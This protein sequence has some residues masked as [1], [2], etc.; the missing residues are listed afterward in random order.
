MMWI[1]NFESND[2]PPSG[3]TDIHVRRCQSQPHG[4]ARD[5]MAFLILSPLHPE[6]IS[7]AAWTY[8]SRSAGRCGSRTRGGSSS[9]PCR[10]RCNRQ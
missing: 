8:C 9:R 6:S 10:G 7:K 3:S 5:G 2:F 4:E 1:S